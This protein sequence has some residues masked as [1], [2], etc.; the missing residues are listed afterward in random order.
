MICICT[1]KHLYMFA[2]IHVYE[3]NEVLHD[4]EKA[5]L[6][7]LVSFL[8]FFFFPP[9]PNISG[10][11]SRI[12][13]AIPSV[14]DYQMRK[15]KMW[16]MKM[17]NWKRKTMTAWQGSHRMKQYHPP[18]SPEEH[19]RM[20][21]MKSPHL[22]PW[23]LTTPEGEVGRS[24]WE[25]KWG[26]DFWPHVTG[27]LWVLLFYFS[28]HISYLQFDLS[29]HLKDS[30]FT[31]VGDTKQV[32]C[33][34]NPCRRWISKTWGVNGKRVSPKQKAPFQHTT[35]QWIMSVSKTLVRAQG[36]A[37]HTA[38]FALRYPLYLWPNVD[39]KWSHQSAG[40][41]WFFF[42]WDQAISIHL[43][44]QFVGHGVG[45]A[46]LFLP[47]FD[48]R[49]KRPVTQRAASR[50][51]SAHRCSH[52]NSDRSSALWAWAQRRTCRGVGSNWA[53]AGREL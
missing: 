39:F 16:M 20:K 13:M 48:I 26:P 6:T 21:K 8:P 27:R 15:Q 23:A 11:K 35:V 34:E 1:E 52:C 17:K 37:M 44:N 43:Q 46:L 4:S 10:Q 41:K 25:V 12:L 31:M 40:K 5:W 49:N 51:V 24:L 3:N 33:K 2:C 45:L 29:I 47:Q 30:I 38:Q 9:W 42:P 19:M 36:E 18:Q 32:D 7:H 53:P 28:S 14:T 50:L 22:S